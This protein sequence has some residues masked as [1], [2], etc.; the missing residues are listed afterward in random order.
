MEVIKLR[1]IGS[2]IADNVSPSF[3]I[4]RFKAL[5]NEYVHPGSLVGAVITDKTFVLGRISG[6]IEVNPHESPT[7]TAVRHA[8][9]IEADYPGEGL[10][11]TIYRIY[12]A[13]IIEQG[14]L[15]KDGVEIVEPMDMAKAGASVFIPNEEV[16]SKAMGFQKIQPKLFQ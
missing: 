2:V 4:F 3:D 16:I 13:D 7:R 12:E 14:I 8:M 6:S 11:T 1:D 15:A 9:E 10:S 5:A